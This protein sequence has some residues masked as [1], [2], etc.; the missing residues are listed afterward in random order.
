MTEQ[1]T[2]NAAPSDQI[3]IDDLTKLILADGLKLQRGDKEIVYKV[4]TLRETGVRE[5][6]IAE[7][8]SERAVMAG[9]AWRLMHSESDF[10]HA[11]N[12]LHIE[13]FKCDGVEIGSGV[14]DL[15]M[16]DRLSSRDLEL[17]E[18][19]IFLMTM[20]AEVRY[21]NVTQQY[22]E[23]VLAGVT[24]T[25]LV[26]APQLSGQTPDVGAPADRVESGP[27]LLADL[28]GEHPHG[29]AAHDAAAAD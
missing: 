15:D 5:E 8:L 16:Y 6:R 4:V 24:A 18:Q 12:M 9:G 27:T 1:S 3:K 23:E 11:L 28:S 17:I 19:R 14:I 10:K 26:K 2:P 22:F 13:S 25:P 7:K 20:A 21:G 29:K